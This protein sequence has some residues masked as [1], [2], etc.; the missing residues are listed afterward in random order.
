MSNQVS[1]TLE[2]H[3]TAI[4]AG[5]KTMAEHWKEILSRLQ[6]VRSKE[7]WRTKYKTYTEFLDKVG[8]TSGVSPRRIYELLRAQAVKEKL[9]RGPQSI[10]PNLRKNVEK[11]S[12]EATLEI[13]KLPEA[14]R[15]AVIEIAAEQC[16]NGPPSKA[17]VAAAIK[18][19]ALK[20][21]PGKE[22][23]PKPCDN[24]GTVIQNSKLWPMWERRDEVQD[25]LTQLSNLKSKIKKGLEAGDT[26][27]AWMGNAIVA[28]ISSLYTSLTNLKLHA[29]CTKCGGWTDTQ[30]K[31]GCGTCHGLGFISKT[32]Y[33]QE[34]KP[35]VKEMR[36]RVIA[37]EGR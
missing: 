5:L 7:L 22:K 14:E 30:G 20:P 4:V 24:E 32:H 13:S 9:L 19:Q 8:E 29:V 33:D 36:K 17:A 18:A 1:S 3:E 25:H 15:P 26:L 23:P 6:E 16:K 11:L 31:A 12:T 35:E 10:S 28:D 37:A 2:A 21:K 34:S 27:Y